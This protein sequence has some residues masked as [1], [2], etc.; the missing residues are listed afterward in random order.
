M[1]SG[2]N[3]VAFPLAICLRRHGQRQAFASM[4]AIPVNDAELRRI[5]VLCCV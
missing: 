5:S 3:N 4:A 2:E 1:S